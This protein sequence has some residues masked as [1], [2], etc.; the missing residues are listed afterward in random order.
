[1]Y[2]GK[3]ETGGMGHQSIIHND[4]HTT[5]LVVAAA[6]TQFHSIPFPSLFFPIL[7]QYRG[8]YTVL[9]SSPSASASLPHTIDGE[10]TSGH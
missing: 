1:M 9:V 6:A 7:Q 10:R 3:R 8:Y 5:D 2:V 4:N